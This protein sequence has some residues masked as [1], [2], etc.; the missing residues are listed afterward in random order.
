MRVL[1]YGS[2]GW[3]G[4]QFTEILDNQNV[5]YTCGKSRLN[6]YDELLKEIEGIS[7]SHIVTLTGRTHGK[8]GDKVYSTIDYL[9]QDDKLIENIRDNL[10]GPIT[11]SNICKD[12]KIHL[13]YLGTGC[14]FKYEDNKKCFTESCSPNFYGSSYSVVKGFTDQLMKQFDKNVLNLRIRMP[15]TNK[16]NKR[17]FITKIT[18]YDK[19][20]SVPN[21]MTVLTELLPYVVKMMEKGLVGT[22]N[23]TNPGVISHN[24]ILE[25]YKEIVDPTF[26]YKNFTQ[27]EQKKILAAD[28]S[29]N[30][31]NTS[32][33]EQ[34]FPDILNIKDSVRQC[35]LEYKNSCL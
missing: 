25:M 18:S 11:L 9:E 6:E 10:F 7:P 23:F 35:L 27:E 34:M 26:K 21:S 15:I 2:N 13:T 12:K 14:I 8:I 1:V 5:P 32:L 24:E 30:M 16:Y 33:L 29:N 17:N 19:I 22:L 20:C 4:S 31:L 3:I 28:R